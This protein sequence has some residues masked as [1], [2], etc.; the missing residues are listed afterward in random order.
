MGRKL[1]EPKSAEE[2]YEI[3]EFANSYNLADGSINKSFWIGV[4][5]RAEE[6]VFTYESDGSPVTYTNWQHGCPDNSG[7]NGSGDEDCVHILRYDSYY[8][9][10]LWNDLGCDTPLTSICQKIETG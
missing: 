4:N 5:D 1:A 6:G 8:T 10:Y 7:G 3:T 2:E 9:E